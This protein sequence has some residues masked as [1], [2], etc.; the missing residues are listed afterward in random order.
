MSESPEKDASV[1][2]QEL[3]EQGN[4]L[5]LSRKYLEAAA[6]YTKAIVRVRRWGACSP[7]SL[8]SFSYKHTFPNFHDC[9]WE[10]EES[11][12]SVP[13]PPCVCSPSEPQSLHPGV[14]H[15]QSAV[16]REAAAVR[17][18]SGRLQAGSGA[19]QPVGQSAFLHGTV[20]PGDGKLRRGHRQPAERY[21]FRT[22]LLLFQKWRKRVCKQWNTALKTSLFPS[23]A[24]NLAK[25]QRLN[26]GDDIPSALRIA[27]KK[28]WNSMEERR[29]N[30]ES[31][32]QAYLTKLIH[33]EKKRQGPRETS[34]R[35]FGRCNEGSWSKVCLS[36]WS[37]PQRTGTLQTEARG[38]IRRQQSPS[39]SQRDPHQTRRLLLWNS[40]QWHQERPDSAKH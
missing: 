1:S 14:L 10:T 30:Q 5:F 23:P 11:V 36:V 29:I 21:G 8:Y 40:P 27:K 9:L 18:S 7:S 32:L 13:P 26:F 22:R 37:D 34:R 15:Q 4:R 2:A 24:Y 6:C 20:S 33:A 17:Q 31:E 39:A 25:E 35:P 28:R 3:K 38:K 12:W 19:R 16:L